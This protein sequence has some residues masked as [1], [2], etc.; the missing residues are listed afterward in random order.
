MTDEIEAHEFLD[1]FVTRMSELLAELR[2][3]TEDE[4]RK[5]QDKTL[6]LIDDQLEQLKVMLADA[7]AADT[8]NGDDAT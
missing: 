3:A 8:G 4:D 6:D 2:D 1:N 7:A 5:R